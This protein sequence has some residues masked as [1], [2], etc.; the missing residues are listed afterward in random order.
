MEGGGHHLGTIGKLMISS[1]QQTEEV[2][3]LSFL[4][5]FY[6]VCPSH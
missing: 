6:L 3:C 1:N 2:K 5:P 4:I